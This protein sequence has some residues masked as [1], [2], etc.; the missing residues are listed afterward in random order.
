MSDLA[1][2]EFTGPRSQPADT[3]TD[4]SVAIVTTR[5]STVEKVLRIVVPVSMVLLAIA[6][7]QLH[8]TLNNVPRY[9]MPAPGD[10]AGARSAGARTIP[11]KETYGLNVVVRSMISQ[12]LFLGFG[13]NYG[14]LPDRLYGSPL[15]PELS[16][17]AR[18]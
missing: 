9:I 7:W 10:V 16:L 17:E 1:R 2:S 15:Y 13:L 4:S 5:T 8:I 11:F 3:G 12:K 6:L 18:F 14:P